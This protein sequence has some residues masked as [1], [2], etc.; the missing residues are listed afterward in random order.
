MF[1]NKVSE[2]RIRNLEHELGL[3]RS[4]Y[5]GQK[6]SIENIFKDII[7]LY[8]EVALLKQRDVYEDET[9]T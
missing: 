3:I 9:T 1:G 4:A 8:G 5:Y 6:G 7:K 2:Q